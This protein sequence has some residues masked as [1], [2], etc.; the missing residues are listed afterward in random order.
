M[1]SNSRKFIWLN[2]LLFGL[3]AC[4]K[5][6]SIH[7]QESFVFGTRVEIL[8][9]GLED[10]RA[11]L[12]A[13]AVLREF[14]RLHRTYHAWRPSELYDLNAA[15]AAGE[16]L[17][18]SREMAMLLDDAQRFFR[19]YQPPDDTT[20]VTDEFLRAR[21]MAEPKWLAYVA[22]MLP[23]LFGYARAA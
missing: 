16:T 19:L 12:A 10:T 23:L 5:P 4:S 2:F 17:E 21:L 18:V 11:R 20:P 22:R 9:A 7:Q 1:K 6:P 14:D 8:I 15:L 3:V 13:D